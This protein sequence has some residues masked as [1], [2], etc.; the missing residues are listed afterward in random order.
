M[1]REVATW[2]LDAA[3]VVVL[4]NWGPQVLEDVKQQMDFPKWHQPMLGPGVEAAVAAGDHLLKA[5][6][7][8]LA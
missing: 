5:V 1:R 3:A 2:M 8:G 6:K 4:M 7:Q